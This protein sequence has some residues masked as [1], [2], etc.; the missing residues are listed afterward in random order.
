M[1]KN[2]NVLTLA[3]LERLICHG[4]I[5]RK[6]AEISEIKLIFF[7]F[8]GKIFSKNKR[9]TKYTNKIVTAPKNADAKRIENSFNPSKAMRGIEK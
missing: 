8:C 1:K 3:V 2:T 7:D 6:K 5:A 4:D 9:E